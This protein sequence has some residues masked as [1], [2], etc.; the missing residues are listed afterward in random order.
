MVN[1][2]SIIDG[3]YNGCFID[4]GYSPVYLG[5]DPSLCVMV[6]EDSKAS[7]VHFRLTPLPGGLLQIE[8]CNSTNGTL[9]NGMRISQAVIISPADRVQVGDTLFRFHFNSQTTPG[10][11]PPGSGPISQSHD[12]SMPQRSVMIGRDPSNDIVLDH[13]MVSRCHARIDYQQGRY[14]ITD[15]GSTNGSYVNGVRINRTTPLDKGSLITVG[16]Y[17][18]IFDG[19]NLAEDVNTHGQVQ[20]QV[21]QLGKSVPLPGG[22]HKQILNNINMVIEPM[23]FVAVLGGSGAGKTTLVGALTGMRPATYGQILINGIDFYHNYEAFRSLIAYVPQDD[24]VHQELTVKEVLTYAARLRMPDD[25]SSAEIAQN[26][27][28]VISELELQNQRDVYVKNLSG[29][30]RKRVSI[31]VELITRPSLFFLDEP[32]S[33]LDPG[34]EKIMMELMRKLANQGR[35]IICITH[36]TF[37]IHLC[38]KVIFLARDGHLAFYGTPQE[39]LTYFQ[40][41]D[42]AEIYRRINTEAS[43]EQW[44][45]TY[46]QSSFCQKHIAAKMSGDIPGYTG[47]HLGEPQAKA[48]TKHSAFR[49]WWVLTQ[50]YSS[51]VL[52]DWR[53]FVLLVMQ[54]IIIPLVIVSIFYQDQPLFRPSPYLKAEL[55]V[56]LNAG[57]FTP[58]SNPAVINREIEKTSDRHTEETKRR[59]YVTFVVSFIV[60]T[61]IWL[62]SMNAAREIVKEEAIY[63]RER[64]VTLQIAPYIMSKVAILSLISFVQSVLF[65]FIMS[66]FLGLPYF[67][68]NVLAFFVISLSSILMGLTIS[69]LVSN[70]E[71]AMSIIPLILIPQMALSGAQ[72]PANEVS[73][74]FVQWLFNISIS[75]WGYELVG[76]AICQVNDLFPLSKRLVPL[77]GP[78]DMHWW[79]LVYFIIFFYL[80]TTL[81]L[82][83]KDR[84][85]E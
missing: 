33:G 7:R 43:P 31:G 39:A 81:V 51:I 32:T 8:D 71:K 45:W 58:Q 61:A 2:I 6:I 35:T 84:K 52:R 64:R 1:T 67:W 5:R 85:A 44:A 63:K 47:S 22:S 21:R 57:A 49:Q 78:F 18:Y 36:A 23:E 56:Q 82:M 65:V 38:N 59:L 79:V 50:R 53:N 41:Q 17:N 29:G 20:I 76:G 16:T 14:S 48:K 55:E 19:I 25:A 46:M 3:P 75:K 40:T 83:Y 80:L 62:G 12:V 77:E 9:V 74:Q 15:L 28:M 24:I 4:S 69:A 54:A 11:H 60:L 10:P 66:I 70:Q 68:P 34:L 13:P 30:Q 72:V 27:D 37:N 42:F 73:F 26:V